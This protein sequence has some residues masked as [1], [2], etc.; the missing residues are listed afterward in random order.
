[1]ADLVL[2]PITTGYNVSN[3]NSNFDDIEEI[4]NTDLIHKSGGH[5]VLEQDLDMDSNQILNIQT[6]EDIAHC[7][8]N[9]EFVLSKLANQINISN[10]E[11]VVDELKINVRNYSSIDLEGNYVLTEEESMCPLHLIRN[12]AIGT[13]RSITFNENGKLPVTHTF[14]NLFSN[15]PIDL[16]FPVSEQTFTIPP[17]YGNFTIQFT[18]IGLSLYRTPFLVAPIESGIATKVTYNE[19][20]IIIFAEQATTADIVDTVD[21]RYVTDAQL[22][23][24]GVGGGSFDTSMVEPST[25][26]NYVTDE[27]KVILDGIGS[28]LTTADVPASTNRNYVTDTEKA[29]IVAGYTGVDLT[30]VVVTSPAGSAGTATSVGKSF[31]LGKL[32]NFSFKVTVNTKPLLGV[33]QDVLVKGMP[34]AVDS[35]R[36]FTGVC[37]VTIG[38]TAYNYTYRCT[39]PDTTTFTIYKTAAAPLVWSDLSNGDVIE[40]TGQ[41]YIP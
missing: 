9:V 14:I 38:G 13:T 39:N 32:V 6:D 5:N 22:A 11:D 10:L 4:V 12:G 17:S 19:D 8:A 2:T 29:A 40:I 18:P 16:V 24:I 20:G 33:L 26:R 41:A 15:S 28:T 37:K 21:K 7:A 36:S 34:F 31:T 35:A 23:A 25:N 30:S 27:Q 3:I 1:M